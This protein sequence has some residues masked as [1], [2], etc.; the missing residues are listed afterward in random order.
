MNRDYFLN[1]F[2]TKNNI[3]NI[4]LENYKEFFDTKI[5][6]N[7]IM[8]MDLNNEEPVN[9]EE[10]LNS[11][12]DSIIKRHL[13]KEYKN[14]FSNFNLPN[15]NIAK[16]SPEK[17]IEK[18]LLKFNIN[19][20]YDYIIN[21]NNLLGQNIKLYRIES[22]DNLG[23]YDAGGL[24]LFDETEKNLRLDPY[25]D[26][27]LNHIFNSINDYDIDKKY[28]SKWKFA[29]E[30]KEDLN[31]WIGSQ[32]TYEN[33]INDNRCFHIKELLVPENMVIKGNN[34]VIYKSEH[35]RMTSKIELQNLNKK[36]IVKN[37]YKI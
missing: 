5:F 23:I 22:K 9:T 30:N 1:T 10:V 17:I 25:N 26:N 4:N 33:I 21:E 29:F 12:L 18:D 6:Q 2:K 8:T 16:F 35:V 31:K 34:Q 13:I 15:L 3:V 19:E 36:S 11:R 37:T 14:E 27:K 24:Y 28:K 20:L 7:L 32:K